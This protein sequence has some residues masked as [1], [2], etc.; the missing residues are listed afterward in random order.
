MEK[1]NV[2]LAGKDINTEKLGL[3]QAAF[4]ATLGKTYATGI[5][6]KRVA[7]AAKN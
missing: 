3:N 1:T 4:W 6:V 2:A 7:Q 5:D